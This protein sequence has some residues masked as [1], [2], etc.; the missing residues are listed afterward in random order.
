MCEWSCTDTL[1]YYICTTLSTVEGGWS[2]WT[3]W[4]SC[5]VSCGGGTRDRIRFC[6]YPPP[7][8]NGKY[9]VG[10]GEDYESCNEEPCPLLLSKLVKY[11]F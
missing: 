2:K 4:G 10:N 6:N 1:F 9:C 8:K 7:P 3:P 5:S 11:L